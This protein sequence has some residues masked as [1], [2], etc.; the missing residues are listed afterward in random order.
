[1]VTSSSAD[2]DD[3]GVAWVRTAMGAELRSGAGGAGPLL[4]DVT[5]HPPAIRAGLRGPPRWAVMLCAVEPRAC[6]A[7]PAQHNEFRVQKELLRSQMYS[8]SDRTRRDRILAQ[9]S[10]RVL[11]DIHLIPSQ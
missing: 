5:W 11:K 2:G 10:M 4:I 6:Y 3:A 8:E 1:M 7:A 9:I